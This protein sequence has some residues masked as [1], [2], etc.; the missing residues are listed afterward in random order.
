MKVAIAGN[1]AQFRDWC[2]M[3]NI[4]PKD[5]EYVS[6]PRDLYGLTLN[7]EDIYRIGTYYKHPN[8]DAIARELTCRTRQ[9]GED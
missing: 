1:Y 2:D 4:N 9:E 6:S 8:Y 7:L 5:V 3:E